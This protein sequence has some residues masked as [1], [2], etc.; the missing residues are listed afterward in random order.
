[1]TSFRNSAGH[2]PSRIAVV[3][4]VSLITAS[5]VASAMAGDRRPTLPVQPSVFPP[6]YFAVLPFR[7]T[8]FAPLVGAHRITADEAR[9]RNHFRF[10]YDSQGRP[11]RVAFMLGEH[12]RDLNDTA[13]YYFFA[14][15][16][17]IHYGPGTETRTF[18]D[19]NGNRVNADGDVFREEYLLDERGYRRALR[20]FD[21][22]DKPSTNSWD[23]SRY[24]WTIQEDGAVVEERYDP[25]GKPR[26]LRPGVPFYRVRFRYGP[27]GW[28]A[29]MQNIGPDGEPKMNALNAAQDRLEYTADGDLLSWNVLDDTGAL[30]S[31]NG[32]GVAR[33]ILEKNEHGYD[34][35]ERY[36][37]EKG[38]AVPS[39]YGWSFDRT[40]YDDFGNYAERANHTLDGSTLLLSDERGYAGYRY[41]YD[42]SGLDRTLLAF[43]DEERQP[44]ERKGYG[45]EQI[46]FEYDGRGNRTRV[47]FENSNGVLVDRSDNGV[48]VIEHD[49]DAKGRR[50]ETRHR[51][52]LGELVSDRKTG[53][54]I[55]KLEYGPHGFPRSVRRFNEQ[56]EAVE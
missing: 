33:G 46:R 26:E 31:G 32:P 23:V 28:L 41:E 54:A 3:L 8:P 14:P 52:R 53:V 4:A 24:E 56:A 34:V 50:I 47:R 10:E 22:E 37:N 12:V 51:N 39:A 15:V 11:I 30:S 1:M 18:F 13:N 43:F 6:Q 9:T 44:V 27:A 20:F 55:E 42:S 21:A 38:E 16:V 29:V 2:C 49:Y 40:R 5:A 25:E 19:R 35:S 45:Y 48:A 7:E 36:E 17:E